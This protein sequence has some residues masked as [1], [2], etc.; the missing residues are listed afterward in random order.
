MLSKNL[1]NP[2]VIETFM[3]NTVNTNQQC[4]QITD[5]KIKLCSNINTQNPNKT[6]VVESKCTMPLMLLM[7]TIQPAL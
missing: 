2:L 5:P 3:Y 7:P 6:L 1:A 4:D